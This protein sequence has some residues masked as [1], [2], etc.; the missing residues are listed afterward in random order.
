MACG[1]PVLAAVAT[2]TTSIVRDGETGVLVEPGDVDGFADTL[3]AYA[4]DPDIRRRH[5][6]AGLEYA[7]SMDWDSINANALKTYLRV[8]ERRERIDRLKR[9]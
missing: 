1:L 3:E 4:R 9:R 5:G 6:E 2:G 7:K 8:I